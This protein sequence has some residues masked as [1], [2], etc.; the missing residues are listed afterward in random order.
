MPQLKLKSI[1]YGV[2][3][4][5]IFPTFLCL[6]EITK[7]QSNPIPADDPKVDNVEKEEFKTVSDSIDF[8]VD[9]G[10]EDESSWWGG[11]IILKDNNLYKTKNHDGIPLND[12]SQSVK[13][14]DFGKIIF[15][16]PKSKRSSDS[17]KD[18]QLPSPWKHSSV[19]ALPRGGDVIV[20]KGSIILETSSPDRNAT[21]SSFYTAYRPL[22]RGDS[23]ITTK[24]SRIDTYEQETKSGI[25]IRSGIAPDSE[26][27]FLALSH[28]RPA[29][30][31]HTKNGDTL[32]KVDPRSNSRP[33]HWIRLIREKG[34]ITGYVS[35]DGENWRE[36]MT[37]PDRMGESAI[38]CI[39]GQGRKPRR[40]WATVFD[41]FSLGTLKEL[42]PQKIMIPKIALT[43]GTI[44]HSPIVSATKSIIR[45]GGNNQGRVIP[46]LTV[47]RIE[48]NHPIDGKFD[49]FLDGRRRGVLLS[50]GDFFEC[51]L[52]KVF[53]TEN[54]L[55]MTCSS[56]LFGTKNFDLS[57]AVDAM[58]FR[59]AGKTTPPGQKYTVLTWQGGRIYGNN[60]RLNEDGFL[61]DTIRLRTQNIPLNQIKSITKN[62]KT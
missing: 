1:M 46:S 7:G 50:G 38:A 32:S 2:S 24:V 21:F 55:E 20:K 6:S 4:F 5:L 39:V 27:I 12:A 18:G 31:H 17:F 29:S 59:P 58:V 8:R 62:G 48:F 16:K 61:I 22:P 25:M 28:R 40:K 41:Q 60:L 34:N 54:G 10:N 56:T 14:D 13:L 51:E 43:D 11:H 35:A 36:L 45:L 37:F 44:I 47:S 49:R 42:G 3:L 26:N 19:G 33:G 30:I 15:Y 53:R 23:H 57:G 9:I 52:T